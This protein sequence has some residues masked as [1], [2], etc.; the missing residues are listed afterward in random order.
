MC[1]ETKLQTFE[2]ANCLLYIWLQSNDMKRL[3]LD[4]MVELHSPGAEAGMRS[5]SG[6]R[7][8]GGDSRGSSSGNGST[9]SS[10]SSSRPIAPLGERE[11]QEIVR[12]ASC[13]CHVEAW[14]A[15]FPFSGLPHDNW[16]LKVP[17]NR[18]VCCLPAFLCTFLSHT[19]GFANAQ[20]RHY[21]LIGRS[22]VSGREKLFR[23]TEM[24]WHLAA[25]LPPRG[26]WLDC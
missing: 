25:P 5:S 13:M 26:N 3:V 4:L 7:A 15:F 21:H 22:H 2:A 12:T 8:S 24:V 20:A 11:I 17:I 18:E 10:S 1:H 19:R 14:K 9:G 6:M 23:A 16:R